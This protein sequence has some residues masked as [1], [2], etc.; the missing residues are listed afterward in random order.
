[1]IDSY[2]QFCCESYKNNTSFYW[3][4][5]I[6]SVS[7]ALPI[8]FFYQSLID[9]L[10]SPHQCIALPKKVKDLIYSLWQRKFVPLSN[11][12]NQ[13]IDLII[14]LQVSCQYVIG[15]L[16][17]LSEKSLNFYHDC[18]FVVILVL[19]F[20]NVRKMAEVGGKRMV[21]IL[22]HVVD[23]QSNMSL[24][25]WFHGFLLTWERKTYFP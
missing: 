21:V 14:I 17:R 19:I 7:S 18:K 2:L 6:I 24:A 9:D 8:I 25:I 11:A 5:I 1:M 15:Y 4:N 13:L 10:F 22:P 12:W 20:F 23:L 16:V 3:C